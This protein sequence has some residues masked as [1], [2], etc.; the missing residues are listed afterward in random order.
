MTEAA[1]RMRQLLQYKV[2]AAFITALIIL[3]LV[4]LFS[5]RALEASRQSARWVD[6]TY[7]ILSKLDGVLAS[8]A[9]ADASSRAFVITDDEEFAARYQGARRQAFEYLS[10]VSDMTIDNQEQQRALPDVEGYVARKMGIADALIA[11]RRSGGIDD[12]LK[13]LPPGSAAKIGIDFRAAVNGMKRRE[14]ELLTAREDALSSDL[15]RTQLLLV[16]G[17]LIGMIITTAAGIGTIIDMRRRIRAE[18]ALAL[19]KER[20]QV[21]LQSIGDAVICTDVNGLVTY[22]NPAAAMLTGWPWRQAVGQPFTEVCPTLHGTTREP[23]GSRIQMAIAQ[24]RTVHLPDQALLVRR[25]GSEVAIEDTVAPI[26]GKDGEIAGAVK[27]FRD[28]SESHEQTRQLQLAAQ[29]DSLTGLPN[30]LLLADRSRQAIALAGREETAVAMLFLDLN[31]FKDIN[32]RYGHAA[33]DEILMNVATRLKACVRDCDTVCRLGGDEF[34]VLLSKL[35]SP[36][37]ARDAAERILMSLGKPHVYEGTNLLA[38]ASIGISVYPTDATNG[39]ALLIHADAAMYAAKSTGRATYR[40]YFPV[41]VAQ[42][43]LHKAAG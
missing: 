4:A 38:P 36:K 29:H 18:A 37:D 32:D 25:D 31:G 9:L 35:D 2:H 7:L 22:M 33:G 39:E 24:G 26:R 42:M 43:D 15:S 11:A 28:V 1:M 17:T 20:A 10:D 23:I 34:V 14:S 12:A 3:L 19:E 30:R 13:S 5:Y 40:F 27:V 8:V 21:T 41:D 16:L 6:H